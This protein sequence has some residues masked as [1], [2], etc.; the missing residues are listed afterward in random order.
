MESEENRY[1]HVLLENARLHFVLHG[2][3]FLQQQKADWKK[4]QHSHTYYE[5]LFAPEN[6]C[7]LLLD[8]REEPLKGGSF[9][10][11]RPYQRHCAFYDKPT[12]LQSIGF[13]Y[14]E[15][16]TATKAEKNEYQGNLFAALEQRFP[17]SDYISIP[18]GVLQDFFAQLRGLNQQSDLITEGLMISVLLQ[19]LF[20]AMLLIESAPVSHDAATETPH[21]RDPHTRPFRAIYQIN[22]VLGTR[23][24]EDIT[25]ESL[26]R[27]YYI[28]VRQINSYIH[29]LYG[30]TFLQRRASLRVEAAKALL[31][32]SDSTIAE[33]A[34]AVGYHSINTFFSAFKARCNMTPDQYRKLP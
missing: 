16:R 13:F 29:D 25:P 32:N 18:G 9:A 24:T 23:Y 5:I 3:S 26:S 22:N 20:H 4:A 27:E 30:E 21:G 28:S 31:R 8:D 12:D 2:E 15:M 33:I 17:A 19:I 7:R 14:T 10:V 1:F 11:I 6:D 34:A